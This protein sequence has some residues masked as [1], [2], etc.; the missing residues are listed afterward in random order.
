M[1]NAG[2]ICCAVETSA[3]H[4]CVWALLLQWCGL[5]CC[6]VVHS[7][8][9]CLRNAGLGG[10]ATPGRGGAT[11]GVYAGMTPGWRPGTDAGGGG[12]PGRGGATPGFYAG[13]TP[14]M[15]GKYGV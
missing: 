5:Y 9:G 7:V 6:S 14:G 2:V 12:T 8:T 13:M 1:V 15:Q 11:P 4:G 10:D 3:M